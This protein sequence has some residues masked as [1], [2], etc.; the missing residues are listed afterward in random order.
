MIPV[1]I[2]GGNT[3]TMGI[4]IKYAFVALFIV[5]LPLVARGESEAGAVTLLSM[6][7]LPPVAEGTSVP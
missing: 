6:K 7:T 1:A 5:V 4:A 2:A 3:Y